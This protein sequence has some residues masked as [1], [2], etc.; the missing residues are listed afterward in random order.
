MCVGCMGDFW[1]ALPGINESITA[2]CCC[3]CWTDEQSV[4][5]ATRTV[6]CRT[7]YIDGCS[8]WIEDDMSRDTMDDTALYSTTVKFVPYAVKIVS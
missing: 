5:G 6:S 4:E 7:L 1:L 8:R 3:C 2:R